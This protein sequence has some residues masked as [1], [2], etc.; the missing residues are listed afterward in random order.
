MIAKS[1]RFCDHTLAT[2][3]D[4]H[5]S[6]IS[7]MRLCYTNLYYAPAKVHLRPA[8]YVDRLGIRHLP[9]QMA[10]RGHEV[11]VVQQFDQ[12]VT[13]EENGVQYH[14]VATGRP[15]RALAALAGRLLQK[16]PVR[17]E[18]ALRPIRQIRRLQP[19]LIHFHGAILTLNLWLL[20]RILGR[21][22]P[23]VLLHYHGGY[24]PANRTLRR[25][26]QGNFKQ[27]AR[28]FFTT[29]WHARPFV[30]AGTID[31]EDPRVVEIMEVSS[32]FSWQPRPAARRQTGMSG[33]PIFLSVGRLHPVKDPLT[34]LRGF[35]GIQKQWREAHLY[36]HYLT[37]EMLPQLRD[38][39]H[40]RPGLAA[41]VHFRG[42]VSRQAL[43]AA[44]NSAHF[45]LQA[46]RREFSGYAVLEAMSCGVIPVVTDIPS[47]RAMTAGGRY[48][49]LFPPGDATAMAQRVLA[50]DDQQRPAL[51]TAVR[52]HFEREL[53]YPALAERL[54][55]IYYEVFR[56][57]T[58]T[59]HR[60]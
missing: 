22:A 41:Y 47:F 17:L 24:P 43:E 9:E 36:L 13:F 21:D 25:V 35:A 48:G 29:H 26:Q 10:A 6:S 49:I 30:R 50:L 15:L 27:V 1:A 57:R 52:R 60:V 18:M 42:R 54:E 7:S 14:F 4:V 53:S 3:K 58:T 44:Y 51:A 46:S 28:L 38:F 23:P 55:S 8:R 16:P 2:D 31:A 34:M 11:H 32:P 40:R 59:R 45:L 5:N 39:V 33:N 37:D 19:D 12:D 56:E 20:L